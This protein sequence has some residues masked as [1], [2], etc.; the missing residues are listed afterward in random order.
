MQLR[1]CLYLAILTFFVQL[2]TYILQFWRLFSELWDK[3]IQFWG[4]TSYNNSQFSQLW[5]YIMQFWEK[6]KSFEM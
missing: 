5:I 3:N 1:E 2:Q 4:E 6:K